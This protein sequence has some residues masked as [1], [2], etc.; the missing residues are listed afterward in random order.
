[1]KRLVV[2]IF[3]AIMMTAAVPVLAQE[4]AQ[5]K[6]ECLLTSKKC[7][8]QVDTIQQKIRK[9]NK[10]ISKGTKVYTPE[11]LKKLQAKLDETNMMLD[12]LLQP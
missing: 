12:D 8:N 7:A 1:M 11:E 4:T 5:Q 3:S 10:E 6:D 2:L 9:L